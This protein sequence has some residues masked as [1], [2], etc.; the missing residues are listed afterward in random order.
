MSASH[1]ILISKATREHVNE[2]EGEICMLR[3]K[4]PNHLVGFHRILF[5]KV[6]LST[7]TFA[8][9]F[10]CADPAFDVLEVLRFN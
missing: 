3:I 7:A 2:K 10:I 9:L 8:L 6:T 4:L 1:R 5:V